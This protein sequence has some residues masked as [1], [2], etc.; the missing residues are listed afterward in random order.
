MSMQT[1]SFGFLDRL[2]AAGSQQRVVRLVPVLA[3][4]GFLALATVAG[5]V[6]HPVISLAALLLALVTAAIPDSGAPLLLI[7]FLAGVW[8]IE[9]PAT[10]NGWVLLAAAALLAI[11]VSCALASYGPTALTLPRVLLRRWARRAA[12]MAVATGLTWAAVRLV[13]GLHLPPS[14]LLFAGALVVLLGWLSLLTVRLA[15][16]RSPDT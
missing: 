1:R 6:F 9:L 16:R 5:G 12:V 2:S 11:H 14:R 13:G 15:T 10:T 4:A 8:G 7:L 3:T